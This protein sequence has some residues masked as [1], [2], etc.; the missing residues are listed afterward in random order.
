MKLRKDPYA[1]QY[2]E[3]IHP[4]VHKIYWQEREKTDTIFSLFNK[5]VQLRK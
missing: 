2:Y 4:D 1:I 5:I 3:Y